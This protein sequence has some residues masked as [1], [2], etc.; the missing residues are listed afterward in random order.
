MRAVVTGG[1]TER[2]NEVRRILLNE[3]LNC[4]AEDVVGYDRLPDCLAATHPDVVLVYCNGAGKEGLLAIQT[5]HQLVAGP[6]LAVGEPAVSLMREAMRAGARE[7]LDVDNLRQDLSA[8]LVSIENVHGGAS[9]RGRIISVFSPSGGVGVSTIAL[10]LAVSIVR[11]HKQEAEGTTVLIDATPAPSDLSLL[12][13]LQPKHTLAD[14][15]RHQE[16]LDRKLLAG[17]MTVHAS[18]L[19]V[20]PQAGFTQELGL[21]R[22]GVNSALIRQMFVN[23]RKMYESV[24][25]DLGQEF[26]DATVEAMR[27]SN[28]V[29]MTA[30]ADVPGLRRVRWALDTAEAM[31]I[32][33]E[34]FKIV[35]SRYGSRGQVSK[36][37]VEEALHMPI[38]AAIPDNA[39]M[40]TN[41]RNEGVPLAEISSRGAAP[42][43]SLAKALQGKIAGVK[44]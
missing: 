33:R 23:L 37:K 9:K 36:P 26:S 27:L 16:R 22:S 13:D 8:A 35:L 25:V 29:L 39:A 14:V 3:G 6:I 41:A 38:F 17:A 24:V 31:G 34:R 30:I 42:F 40:I 7:F 11:L 21:P 12:L 15:C 5:A 2:I 28:V 20:L 10:N 43:V 4:E 19:H 44:V 1:Q 32:S 18:G